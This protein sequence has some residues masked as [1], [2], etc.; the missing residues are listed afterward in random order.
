M[1]GLWEELNAHNLFPMCTCIHI[2]RCTT[3]Q[4]AQDYRL[5]DQAIRFFTDLNDTFFMVKTHIWLM[6]PLPYI[7]QIY[8]IVFQE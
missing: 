6:D 2:C 8:S 5:E 7:N 4:L 1:K 3:L